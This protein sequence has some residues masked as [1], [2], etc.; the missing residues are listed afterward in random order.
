MVDASV[1]TASSPP[2]K[3]W[4][5]GPDPAVVLGALGALREAPRFEVPPDVLHAP[6]TRDRLTRSRRATR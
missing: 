6:A 1:E 3:L 5:E 4:E 2:R